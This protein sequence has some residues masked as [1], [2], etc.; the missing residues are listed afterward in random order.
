MKKLILCFILNMAISL[1]AFADG[2]EEVM[3]VVNFVTNHSASEV[4][5]SDIEHFLEKEGIPYIVE[6]NDSGVTYTLAVDSFEISEILF[7]YDGASRLNVEFG[8]KGTQ[9]SEK[10]SSHFNQFKK[11]LIKSGYKFT[12]NL[13]SST[14]NVKSYNCLISRLPISHYYFEKNNKKIILQLQNGINTSC[15]KNGSIISNE[16]EGS[17]LYL[18]VHEK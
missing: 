17:S 4:S 15:S 1:N 3:K 9:Y 2:E 10:L 7:F 13:S 14:E 6:K 16:S 11:S 8:T 5:R 12:K 18:S